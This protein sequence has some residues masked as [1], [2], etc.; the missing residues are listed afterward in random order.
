MIKTENKEP[1][2]EEQDKIQQECNIN[3]R[4]EE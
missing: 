3:N 4:A 2:T 1:K